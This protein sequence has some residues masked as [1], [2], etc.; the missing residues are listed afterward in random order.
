MSE[1]SAQG[2]VHHYM[3]GLRFD[4]PWEYRMVIA[5]GRM[6]WSRMLPDADRDRTSDQEGLGWSLRRIAAVM[7][8]RP[9]RTI[10]ASSSLSTHTDGRLRR[11]GLF[12]GFEIWSSKAI[13]ADLMSRLGVVLE[14]GGCALLKLVLQRR[15]YG[16]LEHAACW[17]WVVGVEMMALPDT[18]ERSTAQPRHTIRAA[19]V[20][21]REW[22]APWGSGFG[23]RVSWNALGQCSLCSV[24][25]ARLEGR[26]AEVLFIAPKH[27]W[28]VRR[29]EG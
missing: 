21:S 3:R 6:H 11:K 27:L 13:G 22:N 4:G 24:D 1:K 26:C 29:K 5:S 28:D 2:L 16:K 25:G 17:A 7:A 9:L 20:V 19:L 12:P 23:A 10:A 8:Q 15:Q 18:E 14:S